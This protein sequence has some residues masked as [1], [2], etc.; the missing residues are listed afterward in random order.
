[1]KRLTFL[2]SFLL[3]LSNCGLITTFKLQ[4][5]YENEQMNAYHFKRQIPFNFQSGMII[6]E[7]EVNGIKGNFAMDTGAITIFDDDFAKNFNFK[8]IGK[9]NSKDTNNNKKKRKYVK[10][11]EI[12]IADIS[13]HD[14][15]ASISDIDKLSEAA[16]LDIVG[17]LGVNLMNKAIWQ[18][19]YAKQ[20][21]TIK[22]SRGSLNLI[23]SEK[24]INFV[25]YGKGVPILDLYSD[26]KYLG[27]LL[28]DTGS[29][30]SLTLPSEEMSSNLPFVNKQSINYAA[31]SA[32]QRSQKVT[33]LTRVRIGQHFEIQNLVTSFVEN[34]HLN[35]LG[36]KFLQNYLVTIDWPNQQLILS[37][38]S[39][40]KEDFHTNFG[41][42]IRLFN[43]KIVIGSIYKEA[44]LYKKGLRLND[45]VLKI[46]DL[47]LVNANPSIYCKSRA[48]MKDR[49]TETVEVS[50]KKGSG[51]RLYNAQRTSFL[52]LI[53]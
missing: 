27:E 28:L 30:G 24:P 10:S 14:I 45:E 13:F 1:M 50:I 22:D 26:Q 35:L 23:G 8:T 42:S 48:L 36:N 39:N 18:I 53:K 21:I 5:A 32:K 2:V 40:S 7:M 29:N 3:F 31:Y 46:N 44:K 20:I 25:A 52:K 38:S 34:E 6:V 11:S 49:N 33:I 37:S 12:E 9:L 47:N 43:K 51:S 41:F 17:I 15:V 16:C 19:D 4:D